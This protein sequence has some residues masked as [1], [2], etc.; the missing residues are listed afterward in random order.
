MASLGKDISQIRQKKNLTLETI[1]EDTKIPLHVLESIE[2][3][4]IFN[5]IDKNKTYIRSFVRSYAKRLNIPEDLIV[6]CLD[7]VELDDYNGELLKGGKELPD[8]NAQEQKE[9][10]QSSAAQPGKPEKKKK[11]SKKWSYDQTS[12]PEPNVHSVDWSNMS[13]E[14]TSF[15]TPKPVIIGGVLAIL[16]VVVAI[17]YYLI[18][19]GEEPTTANNTT[20]TDLNTVLPVDS[21]EQNRL[22]TD[23]A[24]TPDTTNTDTL[25]TS[26]AMPDTLTLTVYAAYD[27][28]EPVRI[29]SDID[30]SINPYW[31]E[32]GEAMRFPFI[33]SVKIR[34]QY[35]R[36]ILLLDGHMI[37][38]FRQNYYDETER[39]IEIF[40]NNFTA[41]KWRT[42]PPDSLPVDAP[43]PIGIKDRPTF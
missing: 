42:P 35:N 14:I 33:D 17:G 20:P 34:G 38:N 37:E 10:M 30:G 13:S 25:Q 31:I 36:M 16:V 43:P 5:D 4:V 32:Q 9:K 18:L 40:R 7:K 3:G 22:K 2:S 21:V 23:S 11:Y 29:V 41:P 8:R 27:K 12:T 26:T 24:A 15:R 19:P 28:L 39:F 6:L 1:H